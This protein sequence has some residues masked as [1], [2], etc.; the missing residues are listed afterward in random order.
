MSRKTR[1]LIWSAPLV[2][3]IAVVGALAIFMTAA[4][5]DIS[6]QTADVDYQAGSPMDLTVVPGPGAAKRTSLVITWTAPTDGS[7]MPITGYRID[8]SGDGQ[9]WTHLKNVGADALTY[10]QSPLEARHRKVLP[11]LR[12][13]PGRHRPRVSGDIRSYRDDQRARPGWEFAVEQ[14]IRHRNVELERTNGQRWH[15]PYRLPDSLQRRRRWAY[16]ARPMEFLRGPR[17]VLPIWLVT[18]TA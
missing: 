2:A 8:Q 14:H 18:R 5:G 9:R 7:D 1:K 16:S 12:H 10:T 15:S 17:T 6:A 11:G 4:P 3:V 13:E